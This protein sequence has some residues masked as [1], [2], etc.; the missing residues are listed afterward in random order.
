MYPWCLLVSSHPHLIISLCSCTPG[1]CWYPCILI[2]SYPLVHI[3]WV[4]L[5]ILVSS[6]PHILKF[7]YS[8]CLLV[9]S[10]RYILM[11]LVSC[12]M[13]V[14]WYPCILTSS[15]PSCTPGACCYPHT[16]ISLGSCAPGTCWYPC[17]LTFSYPQCSF[18][19]RK[20]E[21]DKN[22]GCNEKIMAFMETTNCSNNF[23]TNW[24]TYSENWLHRVKSLQMLLL[25]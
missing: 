6:H 12:T 7:M 13:G 2:S 21:S 8:E 9:S 1:A 4:L 23:L 20:L 11:S 5:N 25:L 19:F 24:Y 16:L 14:C 17:I 3:L 22:N 15:Y 18:L 10:H